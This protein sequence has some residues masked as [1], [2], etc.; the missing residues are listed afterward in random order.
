MPDAYRKDAM[1]TS[2]LHA[3]AVWISK[4]AL[5]HD[6]NNKMVHSSYVI[7]VKLYFT[8]WSDYILR[9]FHSFL[10]QWDCN[11]QEFYLWLELIEGLII[12]F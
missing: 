12:W 7:Y 8:G 9:Y 11:S 2:F 4:T 10:N 5:F 3:S 1:H 6:T